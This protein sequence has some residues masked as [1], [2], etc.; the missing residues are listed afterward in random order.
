MAMSRFLF[1]SVAAVAVS[2]SLLQ[3][4]YSQ[5]LSDPTII[6]MPATWQR[7]ALTDQDKTTLRKYVRT[8]SDATTGSPTAINIPLGYKIPDG[9]ELHALPGDVYREA[10]R[11]V[12]YRFIQVGRDTYIV[13]R[14]NRIVVGK[15]D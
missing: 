15:L 7:F 12:G 10:P 14:S 3:R 9:V 8:R 4:A 1:V 5:P 11:L 2:F 13:D 6:D